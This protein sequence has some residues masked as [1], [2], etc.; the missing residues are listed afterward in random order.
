MSKVNKIET[1]KRCLLICAIFASPLLPAQAQQANAQD[2]TLGTGPLFSQPNYEGDLRQHC[3]FAGDYRDPI[4][5]GVGYNDQALFYYDNPIIQTVYPGPT[6]ISTGL[7]GDNINT[8]VQGSVPGLVN[9]AVTGAVV[10]ASA[11]GSTFAG[12]GVNSGVSG[13]D[14]GASGVSQNVN[15]TVLDGTQ[16]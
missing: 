16:F 14:T 3:F 12:N 11:L 10:G 7:V 5:T 2:A 8:T 15:G 4:Q 13:A 6:P 1:A 9:A